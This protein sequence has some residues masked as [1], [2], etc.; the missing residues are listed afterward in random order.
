MKRSTIFLIIV[1]ALAVIIPA[2]VVGVVASKMPSLDDVIG[3]AVQMGEKPEYTYNMTITSPDAAD[4]TD[5][6]I[7]VTTYSGSVDT[8][9]S[10]NFVDPVTG[11]AASLN[12][13]NIEVELTGVSDLTADGLCLTIELPEST[14]L[15]IEN[16]LP[17]VDIHLSSADLSALR[18]ASPGDFTA[19]NANLGAFLGSDKSV[20]KELHFENCNVGAAKLNGEKATLYVAGSNIGAMTVAG[21]CDSVMLSNSNIGVCSWS[22]ACGDRAVIDNCVI[23]THV[24]EGVVDI[25]IDDGKEVVNIGVNGVKVNNNNQ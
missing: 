3:K 14:K 2:L 23:T 9:S 19:I 1:L 24:S 6:Y 15:V 5:C 22:S 11:V 21:D 12:G 13:R 16:T 7:M 4:V 18:M 25:T 10:V 8:L 20:A 17:M